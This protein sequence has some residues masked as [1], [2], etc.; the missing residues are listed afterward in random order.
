MHRR[1]FRRQAE[2]NRD[3]NFQG[4]SCC[5]R[6]SDTGLSPPNKGTEEELAH[7]QLIGIEVRNKEG[8][9]KN[10]AHQGR[11]PQIGVNIILE[12]VLIVRATKAYVGVHKLFSLFQSPNSFSAFL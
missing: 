2:N 11:C 10:A 5:S 7:L 1:R 8:F 3:N 4:E 6:S 9:T 12:Q